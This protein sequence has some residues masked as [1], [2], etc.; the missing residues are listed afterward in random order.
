MMEEVNIALI[1]G[2]QVSDVAKEEGFV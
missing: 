2:K 1:Q